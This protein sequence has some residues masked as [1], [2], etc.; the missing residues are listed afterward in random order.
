MYG[1]LTLFDAASAYPITAFPFN[2]SSRLSPAL[3]PPNFYA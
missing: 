1:A 2:I 3:K